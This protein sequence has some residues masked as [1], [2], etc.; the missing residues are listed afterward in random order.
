VTLYLLVV[1]TVRLS[2]R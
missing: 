2:I 1:I